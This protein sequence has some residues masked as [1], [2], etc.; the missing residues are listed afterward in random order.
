MIIIIDYGIGNLG[1]IA[2]MLKKIGAAAIISSDAA[3][4]C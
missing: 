4:L 2:N 3:I 1:S